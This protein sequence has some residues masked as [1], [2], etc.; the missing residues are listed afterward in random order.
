M[1]R[2]AIVRYWRNRHIFR[3]G[4]DGALLC[5]EKPVAVRSDLKHIINAEFKDSNGLGTRKLRLRLGVKYLGASEK[6]V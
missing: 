3:L 4:E 5:D 1:Q 2:N 6:N